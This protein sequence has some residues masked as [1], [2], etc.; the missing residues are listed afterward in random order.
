MAFGASK[1]KLSG[2]GSALKAGAMVLGALKIRRAKIHGNP[3]DLYDLHFV[4]LQGVDSTMLH[5]RG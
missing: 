5:C 4:A 2:L 3:S 1:R